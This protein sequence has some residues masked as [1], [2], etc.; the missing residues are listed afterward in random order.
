MNDFTFCSFTYNQEQLILQQLESIRY[1]IENFGE[2]ISC[3]YL[4]ADDH[5]SDSTVKTVEKWLENNSGLFDSV[6]LVVSDKNQGVVRNFES[7]LRNIETDHFKILAGD[8]LYFRNNIFEALDLADGNMVI[9]PTICMLDDGTVVPGFHKFIRRL[10]M[11]GSSAEKVKHFIHDQ[12]RYGEWIP[13]PGVFITR[14]LADEGLFEALSH[15]TWIEDIPE[16]YYLSGT[17]KTKLVVTESPLVVYRV[18]SG[19]STVSEPNPRYKNDEDRLRQTIRTR[20]KDLPRFLNPFFYTKAFAL[21]PNYLRS[22]LDG[23]V[24]ESLKRFDEGILKE[25]KAA[26]DHIGMIL[27]AAVR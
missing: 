10:I 12:F 27:E 26:S 22:V 11:C 8:D 19:I 14:E 2:G 1:Q 18:G 16:F 23:D 25:E 20:S 7:A 4:L 13:A 21:L 6:K 5:S 15:Y 3:R 9:S 17:D 24:R